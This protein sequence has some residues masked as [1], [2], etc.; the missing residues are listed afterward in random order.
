[1]QKS[2]EGSTVFASKDRFLWFAGLQI[3]SGG[4]VLDRGPHVCWAL[5]LKLCALG[6]FATRVVAMPTALPPLPETPIRVYLVAHLFQTLLEL[7]MACYN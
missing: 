7:I 2:V 3:T 5:T 6:P 1:V 4:G